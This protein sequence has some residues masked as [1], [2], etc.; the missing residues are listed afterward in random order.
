[1]GIYIYILILLWHMLLCSIYNPQLVVHIWI[2]STH[3]VQSN[4]L[5][6]LFTRWY[7]H[8][9]MFILY[10]QDTY[11]NS[12]IS[13]VK[14]NSLWS[15]HYAHFNRHSSLCTPQYAHPTVYTRICSLLYGYSLWSSWA[16]LFP[17]I[18]WQGK[19]FMLNPFDDALCPMG[20]VY[21]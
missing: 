21:I 10:D 19:F 12:L 14:E 3:C 16:G 17:M 1:M 8:C 6:L 5:S 18:S 13:F 15:I 4:M 9:F 20:C 7:A 11:E 2:C